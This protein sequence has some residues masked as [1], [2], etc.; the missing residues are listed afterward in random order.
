MSRYI[1]LAIYL[2]IILARPIIIQEEDLFNEG[3]IEKEGSRNKRSIQSDQIPIQNKIDDSSSDFETQINTFSNDISKIMS[4]LTLNISKMQEAYNSNTQDNILSKSG[5]VINFLTA[6]RTNLEKSL[7]FLS[8]T[9]D[10]VFD[11]DLILG[12]F[13]RKNREQRERIEQ[14]SDESTEVTEGQNKNLFEIGN[15]V[16]NAK[17]VKSKKKWNSQLKEST[18]KM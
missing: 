3:T 14:E 15:V 5:S 1:I 11:V 8:E 10:K 13:D 7:D 4:A 12:E 2:P 6:V 18:N 16:E 9:E 17:K